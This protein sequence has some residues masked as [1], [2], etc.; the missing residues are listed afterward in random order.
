MMNKGKHTISGT[1]ADFSQQQKF[2]RL[3][4]NDLQI[5]TDAVYVQLGKRQAENNAGHDRSI[6]KKE[7]E[8]NPHDDKAP[9][10]ANE[11]RATKKAVES[12]WTRFSKPASMMSTASAI[13]RWSKRPMRIEMYTHHLSACGHVSLDPLS[14]AEWYLSKVEEYIAAINANANVQSHSVDAD[15]MLASDNFLS[16]LKRASRLSP[17][18]ALASAAA[19]ARAAPASAGPTPPPYNFADIPASEPSTAPIVGA[20]VSLARPGAAEQPPSAA[21]A[22]PASLGANSPRRGARTATSRA[23]SGGASV[24]ALGAWP[25]VAAADAGTEV[26]SRGCASASAMGQGISTVGAAAVATAEREAAAGPAS[27]GA[28]RPAGDHGEREAD[29]RR[30]EGGRR[31]EEGGREGGREW[32]D[33][34]PTNRR[35]PPASAPPPP[36]ILMRGGRGRSRLGSD[37][38]PLVSTRNTL[39]S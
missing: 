16:W 32:M 37:H 14:F 5:S 34:H 17:G 23:G 30:M 28:T 4:N 19:A 24:M 36:R 7:T 6:R 11:E 25:A 9:L 3:K 31:K 8:Q 20:A 33:T 22:A 26:E 39:P 2:K 21:A 29:G 10:T 35:T 13:F 15:P 1:Q 27:L 18:T 38:G 12:A